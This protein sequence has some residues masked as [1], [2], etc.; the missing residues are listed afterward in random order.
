LRIRLLTD[1]G[2]YHAGD[3]IDVV[4]LWADVMVAFGHAERVLTEPLITVHE[5]GHRVLELTMSDSLALEDH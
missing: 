5:D 2:E 4:E 3:V 1:I